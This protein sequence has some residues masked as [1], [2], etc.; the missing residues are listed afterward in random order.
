MSG[1]PSNRVENT[2]FKGLTKSYSNNKKIDKES[3]KWDMEEK[4]A[5]AKMDS[6][7]KLEEMI[8]EPY[9]ITIEQVIK[10]C[11]LTKE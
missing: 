9:K 10:N 3:W 1:E 11:K 8:P 2:D 5:K 7:E 4:L 6:Y